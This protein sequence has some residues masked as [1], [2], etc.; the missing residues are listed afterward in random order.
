MLVSTTATNAEADWNSGTTYASGTIVSYAYKRWES[1]QAA[2]TNNTPDVSPTWWL[3][4]GADNKHAM[5]DTQVSTSTTAV[6]SLTVV[7]APQNVID[8]IAL[9]DTHAAL[10]NVTIR[11][12]LAGPIVYENTAGISGGNIAN[13]YE[14]F[15]S[16]PLVERTQIIF[17]NIPPYS[18][19][20][21]TL[22]ILNSTGEIVSVAQAV[23]GTVFELGGTQYGANAGII[24]YSLKNTDEFGTITFVERAF[25]KRLS[26]L[27][28]V[29]NSEL[30]RVQSVLYTSRAKPSVWI[31]SDDPNFQESLVIYGFY[32]EFSTDIAY[33]NHS[34]CSLEIESLT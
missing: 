19:A 13:W 15:F 25:S 11:D 31:A 30:N 16:D 3:S 4:L 26:A 27:V 10:V 23:F 7:Y 1:L 2:N 21:I 9:I 34:L 17:Y 24:D 12:G 28:Y 20:Y 5:F 29:K 22:E 8:T 14:Y 18:N 6:T 33:P 32:R